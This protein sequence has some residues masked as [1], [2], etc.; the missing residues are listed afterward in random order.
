H[1]RDW[2]L[3]SGTRRWSR[4]FR[5][6]GGDRRL[7]LP[8]CR[9]GASAM[10]K[11]LLT[12]MGAAMLMAGTSSLALAQYAYAPSDPATGAAAGAAG[13]A[14]AGAATGGAVAGPVGAA[15]GGAVGTATGAAAGTAA[16]TANMMA[17]AP[18][19]AAPAPAPLRAPAYPAFGSSM[20]PAPGKGGCPAGEA[21][22]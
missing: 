16:G 1:L 14:A 3:W 5:T 19:A 4:C 17:G 10:R 7:I 21:P 22:Y 11:S 2:N 6:S 9:Y 8:F 18:V 20:A 13:G 12:V 15:V